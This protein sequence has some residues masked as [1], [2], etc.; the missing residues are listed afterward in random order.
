MNNKTRS[1]VKMA[2]FCS[3]IFTFLDLY[4][5][6]GIVFHI[7]PLIVGLI[8]LSALKSDRRSFI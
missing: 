5:N 7:G 6:L 3:F 1:L 4:L 8:L 2:M